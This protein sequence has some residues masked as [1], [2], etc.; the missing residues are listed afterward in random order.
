MYIYI[1]IDIYQQ[2]SKL[3]ILRSLSL[4]PPGSARHTTHKQKQQLPLSLPPYRLWPVSRFSI[5]V[6]KTMRPKGSKASRRAADSVRKERLPT[7]S[8][9]PCGRWCDG[10]GREEG[11]RVRFVRTR[12]SS[13]SLSRGR[14][15][16]IEWV[17][18][19]KGEGGGGVCRRV[20]GG[21]KRRVASHKR[22]C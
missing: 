15:G 14:R 10:R 19:K 1:Y 3:D 6:E 20:E 12:T 11:R 17:I 22:G 8:L 7:K 2:G 18:W 4:H 13:C 5:T 9:K 16:V 21:R